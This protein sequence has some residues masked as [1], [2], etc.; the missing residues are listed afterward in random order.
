M[1]MYITIKRC[2]NLYNTCEERQE[3][4]REQWQLLIVEEYQTKDKLEGGI[5]NKS[6]F[7]NGY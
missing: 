2:A 3:K 5:Y 4:T 6:F 7:Y 1:Q